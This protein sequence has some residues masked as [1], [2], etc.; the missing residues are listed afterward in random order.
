MDNTNDKQDLFAHIAALTIHDV[1]NNLTQLA[2]DA[3]TRGDLASMKVALHASETLTGLLCFYRSETHHLDLQIDSHDPV[4]MLQDLLGN[5]PHSLRD[6]S[7]IQISL[8]TDHAPAIAFYD[9]TLIEMVLN[10]AL[11]NALRFARN[12]IELGVRTHADKI[13]FYVQDDGDGYPQAVL[14]DKDV[15]SPVSRNGTGLGLRLAQR[16]VG[17][18]E[19]SG[20]HG[21]IVLSNSPGAL[22]QLFLP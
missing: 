14:D 10:N 8:H 6:E 9:K 15:N 11:Q 18:H 7:R 4:E 3:E 17:M 2:N 21:E 1:K 12:N 19:S 5:L 13:E 22:F 20:Q 16:V